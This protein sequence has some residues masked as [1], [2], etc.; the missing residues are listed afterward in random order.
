MRGIGVV[1]ACAVVASASALAQPALTPVLRSGDAVPGLD[2]WPERE[3]GRMGSSPQIAPDGTMFLSGGWQGLNPL[4]SA[5]FIGRPG[6]WTPGF[7]HGRE[8]P[9]G[10]DRTKVIVLQRPTY[11]GGRHFIANSIIDGD[12]VNGSNDRAILGVDLLSVKYLVRSGFQTAGAL[13][14]WSQPDTLHR[15]NAAGQYALSGGILSGRGIAVGGPGAGPE[16]IAQTAGPVLGGPAGSVH[17]SNIGSPVLSE[18]GAVA[19][20]AGYEHSDRCRRSA[21]F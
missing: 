10:E 18:T 14:D 12:T 13:G 20:L 9:M 6:D 16:V 4:E 8:G 3:F 21:F 19:Y 2:S 7:W 1:V 5:V 11:G 15:I 17:D